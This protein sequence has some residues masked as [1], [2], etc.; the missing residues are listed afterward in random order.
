MLKFDGTIYDTNK[1]IC[2]NISVFDA[3]ERGLLLQ[4]ILAQL[5][6]FVEYIVQKVYPNGVDTDHIT[7]WSKGGKTTPDNCQ[8][9]CRDCNLKKGA[10]E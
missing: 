7:P 6:N 8:M 10:Q 2:R 9:L 1:V 3:S 4:N 5:R